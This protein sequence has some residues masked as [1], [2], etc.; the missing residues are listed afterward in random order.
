MKNVG[1]G[2]LALAAFLYLILFI[3]MMVMAF[4][5]GVIG[6]LAL[7]GAAILLW[8]ALRERWSNTEDEHYIK[9]VHQ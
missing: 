5:Y 6:L 4:P 9:H 8:V 1:F 3:A 7:S 2:V